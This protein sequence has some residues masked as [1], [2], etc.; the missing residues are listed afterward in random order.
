MTTGIIGDIHNDVAALRRTLE[1]ALSGC[2]RIVAVGDVLDRGPN[3]PTETFAVLD[4]VNATIVIGNHELAYIGGPVYSGM[5]ELAGKAYASNLRSRII[6]GK[7]SAAT[8]A[9]DVL[10]VHGGISREFWHLHLQDTCGT[11]VAL[12]SKQLNLWLLQAVARNNFSHPVFAALNDRVRGPFWAHALDDIADRQLPPF[13]QAVGHTVRASTEW[14][15][16]LEGGALYTLEWGQ[17]ADDAPLGHLV[18]DG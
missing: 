5:R 2:D 9:G 14:I 11:N 18:V 3:L 8:V 1:G 6:D 10:C 16:G 4:E 15:I 13:R 12:I 7:L 17:P